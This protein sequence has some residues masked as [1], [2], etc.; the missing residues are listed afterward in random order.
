MTKDELEQKG[1]KIRRFANRLWLGFVAMGLFGAF[2]SFS[3]P[4]MGFFQVWISIIVLGSIFW[5]LIIF[6]GAI[7]VLTDQVQDKLLDD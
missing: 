7:G 5:L 6:F 4:E 2:W 3:D 1:K